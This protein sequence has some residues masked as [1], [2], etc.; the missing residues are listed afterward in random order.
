MRLAM[1]MLAAG[2]MG[3]A[4]AAPSYPPVELHYLLF[5]GVDDIG[6]ADAV[7]GGITDRWSL[8]IKVAGSVSANQGVMMSSG[9]PSIALLASYD[10]IFRSGGSAFYSTTSFEPDLSLA[11]ASSNPALTDDELTVVLWSL[12]SGAGGTAHHRVIQD[13]AVVGTAN[14]AQNYPQPKPDHITIGARCRDDLTTRSNFSNT[15]FISAVL[16]AGVIPDAELIAW[17]NDDTAVGNITGLDHYWVASDISGSSIPARV[18]SVAMALTGPVA[19]D[20]VAL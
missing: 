4:P 1:R 15:K 2:Q 12:T 8:A 9:G 7:F 10:R 13:G 11:N 17:F 16:V 19:G 14:V 18:G 3:R 20:L 6:I 5:N